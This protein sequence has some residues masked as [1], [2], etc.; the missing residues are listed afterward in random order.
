MQDDVS[1]LLSISDLNDL[2]AKCATARCNEPLVAHLSAHL[3][4]KA[5]LIKNN[6]CPLFDLNCITNLGVCN[7]RVV[8]DESGCGNLCADTRKLDRTLLLSRAR[9]SSLLL[10]QGSKADDI[11]F[12]APFSH[13]QFREGLRK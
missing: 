5:R 7:E 9:P 11:R 2:V 12:Q 3:W 4:I 1:N 6:C 13:Q 10:H 8:S